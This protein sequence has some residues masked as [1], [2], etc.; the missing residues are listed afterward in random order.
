MKQDWNCSA[1]EL[2][3]KLDSSQSGLSQA[4]V[5][6]HQQ[7]HGLN[8]LQEKK[9]KSVF[10]V[11]LSQFADMLVI[12]LLVAALISMVTGNLES[13]LVILAVLIMNAVLGTVQHVKAEKSLEGLKAMSAPNARVLRDGKE[14]PVLAGIDLPLRG[15]AEVFWLPGDEGACEPSAQ[16][17]TLS[18][19]R[20]GCIVKIQNE[21]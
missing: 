8:Q 4:Q 1:Q 17:W 2:F 10:M 20:R 3:E 19:F 13:T 15:K 6:A 18:G 5:E 12:V 11:F 7:A 21:K 16:G 9:K 14:P